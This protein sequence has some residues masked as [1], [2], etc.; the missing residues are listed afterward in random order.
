[1]S[2]PQQNTRAR[3]PFEVRFLAPPAAK[4]GSDGLW[5]TY[6]GAAVCTWIDEVFDGEIDLVIDLATLTPAADEIPALLEHWQPMG[7]WSDIAIGAD[8]RAR[9]KLLDSPPETSGLP[10]F[11]S[12]KQVRAAIDQGFP[13]QASVGVR[14]GPTG[15]FERITVPTVVNGVELTPGDRP[16]FVLR[17]GVLFE[18]SIVLFGADDQTGRVAAS[19]INHR[20]EPKTM[21]EKTIKER[22]DALTVKFGA[23]R[24]AQIA[25]LLADGCTDPEAE[26]EMAKADLA[27]KDAALAK[28]TA[29]LAAANAKLAELQ[30]QLDA[31]KP[32]EKTDGEGKLSGTPPA[33]DKPATRL[34]AMRAG[35]KGPD[36]KLLTGM[37]ALSHLNAT[38][39]TLPIK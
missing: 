36:G 29:D 14:P 34:A 16:L 28:A 39:P 10:M 20:Q 30:T 18:T 19:A 2:Q 23:D 7:R 12:A 33:G 37:A 24:R 26:Q 35:V 4:P 1:M 31:L 21:T 38:A 17:G 32:A 11:D 6:T 8:V 5:S 9:L 13:W 22:L 27:A 25:V 3:Q 15:T